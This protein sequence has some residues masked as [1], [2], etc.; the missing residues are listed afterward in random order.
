MRKITSAPFNDQNNDL[1]WTESINQAGEVLSHWSCQRYPITDSAKRIRTLS[2][3]VLS[4]A[5]FGKSYS[6]KK[7]AESPKAGHEFNY[8]G[9]L[10]H[11]LDHIML[12]L[13]FGP[14]FL[15]KR[16]LPRKMR[17]V[18]Q[19]ATDFKAYMKEMYLDERRLTEECQKQTP[20][21][22]SSLLRASDEAQE[23]HVTGSRD[24]FSS[25][26]PSKGLSESEVYGNLFVYNFAG[27][28]TTAITLSWT[29]YLLAANPDVQDWISEE[30]NKYVENVDHLAVSYNQIFPK[31]KRCLA[32]MLEVLRLRNPLTGVIKTTGK[33]PQVLCLDQKTVTIPAGTRLIL[34]T[35][36]IHTHPRYWG[37]ES[38]A[39][40]P[41]RWIVYPQDGEQVM[42]GE[43]LFKPASGTYAPWS[44]GPRVCPGK[45][46]AQVEF[47]AMLCRFFKDHR[48]EPVPHAGESMQ[49]ARLRTL[50]AVEDSRMVL[51]LQMA[52]PESIGLKWVKQS[53]DCG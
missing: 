52:K 50:A 46:F 28:D 19:A 30:I 1:V 6:F 44:G 49:D 7:A 22:L 16:F 38:L 13:I 35:D 5:G 37:P 21:M 45:K 12:L 27:H 25:P 24:V 26:A 41:E 18:G 51:L 11:I 43:E 33:E 23:R 15:S 29:I 4:N 10:E 14:T 48:V 39:W 47:V 36:A 40:R 17:S 20:N 2:L 8:R 3:H 31:L 53:A 42:E 34:N 9:A 32:V